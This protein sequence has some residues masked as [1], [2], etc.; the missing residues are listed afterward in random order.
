MDFNT[1]NL[2]AGVATVIATVT[3]WKQIVSSI[4]SSCRFLIGTIEADPTLANAIYSYLRKE[5][6]PIG[7]RNKVYS[8]CRGFIDESEKEEL[9]VFDNLPNKL[10]VFRKGWRIVLIGPGGWYNVDNYKWER[11]VSVSLPRFMWDSDAFIK[12]AVSAYNARSQTKSR[13]TVK[14]IYGANKTGIAINSDKEKDSVGKT[15]SIGLALEEARN[16]KLLSISHDLEK[17]QVDSALQT[18]DFCFFPE[19]VNNELAAAKRWFNSRAWFARHGVPWRR[20]LLMYSQPGCGKTLIAKKIA[21]S[22]NLPIYVF[23]LA[24]LSNQELGTE[25]GK[26]LQES[27][28][29]ALLEDIDSV[30]D[31][32]TNCGGTNSVLTFDALLNCI[33]GVQNADGVY[34]VITT[35]DMSKIDPALGVQD[36]SGDVS[37]P[38]RIDTILQIGPMEESCRRQLAVAMLSGTSAAPRIEELVLAGAN[39]TPAQFSKLISDTALQIFWNT[40]SNDLSH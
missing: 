9:V 27:P 1:L 36:Q 21:Q 39:K 20:G 15:G 14:R 11:G 16:G 28:C 29:M 10:I 7:L 23:D 35:N 17:I 6:K 33:S 25:W 31:G 19:N 5:A 12:Q 24:S 26:M 3:F 32:R 18:Q 13:F 38:G 8:S 30:F 22:L 4:R 37:R 40:A 34:L 2:T